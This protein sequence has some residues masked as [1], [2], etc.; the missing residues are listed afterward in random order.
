MNKFENLG[1]L[2]HVGKKLNLTHYNYNGAF[3]KVAYKS[4]YLDRDACV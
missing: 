4:K 2:S 3:F 1:D